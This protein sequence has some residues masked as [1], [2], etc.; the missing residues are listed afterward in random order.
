[1]RMKMMVISKCILG[2]RRLKTEFLVQMDGAT[3]TDNDR[4]LII[5]ATNLPN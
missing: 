3:T 1:M 5:G 4:V 2:S